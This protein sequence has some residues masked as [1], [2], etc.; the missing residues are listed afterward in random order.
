MCVCVFVSS[1][2]VEMATRPEPADAPLGEAQ[3]TCCFL[4]RTHLLQ[5]ELAVGSEEE[6]GEGA[7]EHARLNVG[8]DVGCTAMRNRMRERQH[9]CVP[10]ET[11]TANQSLAR[12]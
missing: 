7:M 6:D 3:S 2:W 11:L 8:P 1:E 12:A 5:D 9:T 10:Y 4:A